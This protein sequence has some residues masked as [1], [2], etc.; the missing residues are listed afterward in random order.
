MAD[1]IEDM[2]LHNDM[3]PVF[4]LAALTSQMEEK[5]RILGIADPQV[6]RSRLK[7]Q[8]TSL[9]PGLVS[10]KTGREVMLYFEEDAGD[11]IRDAIAYDSKSDGMCLAH[12][13]KIIRRDLFKEYPKF[14]G[15]FSQDFVPKQCVSKTLVL[16]LQMILERSDTSI[17]ET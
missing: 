1:H 10:C 5:M 11:A 9:I 3:S 17:H 13:A 6:H 15:S 16:L 12:A 7:E 8:L 4:K 2:Y 14:T